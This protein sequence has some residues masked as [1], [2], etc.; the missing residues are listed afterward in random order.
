[1]FGCVGIDDDEREERVFVYM[2]DGDDG[3]VFRNWRST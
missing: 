2:G 1:M 3:G